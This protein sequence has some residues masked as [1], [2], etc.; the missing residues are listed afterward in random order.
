[1]RIIT[2]LGALLVA[3]FHIALTLVLA[4]SFLA[5]IVPGVLARHTLKL[6]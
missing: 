5:F 1:M 3:L 4:I 2:F 6:N